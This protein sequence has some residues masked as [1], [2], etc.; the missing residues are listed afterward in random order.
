LVLVMPV[1]TAAERKGQRFARG[2][3]IAALP[4]AGRPYY[5]RFLATRTRI[6]LWLATACFADPDKIDDEIVEVISTCARQFGADR[7]ALY[8]LRGKLNIDLERHLAEVPHPVTLIWADEARGFSPEVGYRLQKIPNQCNIAAIE[9]AGLFPALESPKELVELLNREL[10]S[11][12]R[13]YPNPNEE[14]KAG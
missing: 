2:Q 4:F 3:W 1:G 10:D 14:K 6:R 8:W 12:L 9:K 11:Q 5:Y 13:I 7:A